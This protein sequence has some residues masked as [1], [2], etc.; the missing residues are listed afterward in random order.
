[1]CSVIMIKTV[2]PKSTAL[3]ELLDNEPESG[4]KAHENYPREL[5]I[6]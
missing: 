6:N 4:G 3:G 2:P 1:M 5:N